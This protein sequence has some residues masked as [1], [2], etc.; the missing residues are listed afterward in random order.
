MPS[1]DN[2]PERPKLSSQYRQPPKDTT[3]KGSVITKSHA[4]QLLEADQRRREH[5]ALDQAASRSIDTFAARD[6]TPEPEGG[7][8]SVVEPNPDRQSS[9]ATEFFASFVRPPPTPFD[10]PPPM[11]ESNMAPPETQATNNFS[12]I[13]MTPVQL[14]ELIQRTVQAAATAGP[15]AGP[16][17]PQIVNIMK[18]LHILDPS[19][20]SGHSDEL[21]PFLLECEQCFRIQPDIFNMADKKVF[22]VLSLFKGKLARIWKEQFLKSR[23]GQNLIATD[24]AVFRKALKDSFTEEGRTQDVQKELQ[25]IRQGKM[26]VDELN[27][28]FRLLLQQAGVDPTQNPQLII[29]MY[30]STINRNIALQIILAGAPDT[31]DEWMTKASQIDR[32]FER[33]NRLFAGAASFK[34]KD[35]HRQKPKSFYGDSSNRNQSMGKP[36]DIDRLSPQEN[37]WRKKEKLCFECGKSG[38]FASAH[39]DRTLPVVAFTGSTNK[40]KGKQTKRSF[41]KKRQYNSDRLRTTIRAMIEEN[42]DKNDPEYEKFL[43][44]VEE[45]GFS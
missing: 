28:K 6:D 14:Q 31:L 12:L 3:K 18:D 9:Q 37:K 29:R 13:T 21:D 34:R 26:D 30:E 32:A 40:G 11:P 8:T 44:D 20:F 5:C 36:M 15:P 45:K 42:F 17:G 39:C 7:A 33:S 2:E 24:W 19:P 1:V 27:T 25:E 43:E 41:M 23:E 4:D 22:Y 38:H 16:A 10:P 35:N